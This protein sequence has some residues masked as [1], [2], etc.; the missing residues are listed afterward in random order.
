M[1]TLRIDILQHKKE[2]RWTI[3]DTW[4]VYFVQKCVDKSKVGGVKR[5]RRSLW[6][7][8]CCAVLCCATRSQTNR[9]TWFSGSSLPLVYVLLTFISSLTTSGCW[10]SL[11]WGWLGWQYR[12]VELRRNKTST[13]SAAKHWELRL[14]GWLAGGWKPWWQSPSRRKAPWQQQS[15]LPA[16]AQHPPPPSRWK[17]ALWSR[18]VRSRARIPELMW[19]SSLPGRACIGDIRSVK[20][21]TT[22]PTPFSGEF[23]LSMSTI[24]NVNVMHAAAASEVMLLYLSVTRLHIHSSFLQI[25]AHNKVSYIAVKVSWKTG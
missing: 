23:F 5:R 22:G 20:S 12:G 4:H 19:W 16:S 2:T 6:L 3:V 17:T 9:R 18:L 13:G 24:L 14:V 21:M 10:Q 25:D 15:T 1:C 7:H 8:M 11:G